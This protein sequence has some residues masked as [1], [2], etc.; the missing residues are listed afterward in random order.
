MA[1]ATTRSQTSEQT[2]AAVATTAGVA[3]AT[4]ATATPVTTAA[5]AAAATVTA[6]ASQYLVVTAQKGDADDREKDRDPE[7]QSSIHPLILQQSEYRREA[8]KPTLRVP[9]LRRLSPPVVTANPEGNGLA[10][11]CVLIPEIRVTALLL[12]FTDYVGCN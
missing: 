12:A 1:T 8:L 2:A 10:N 5:I 3:A 4:I 9:P 11:N 6:V 7:G